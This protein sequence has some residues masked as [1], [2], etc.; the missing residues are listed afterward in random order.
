MCG[1][2]VKTRTTAGRT[3]HLLCLQGK[4]TLADR[5]RR[6]W[7][8]NSSHSYLHVLH[9]TLDV[10]LIY[11]FGCGSGALWP[12]IYCTPQN[13]PYNTTQMVSL[14][15]V[16]LNDIVLR[17]N[18]RFFFLLFHFIFKYPSRTLRHMSHFLFGLLYFLDCPSGGEVWGSAY[19][20]F[21]S[22]GTGLNILYFIFYL[23]QTSTS[24]KLQ[25]EL[26]TSRT[27][28]IYLRQL[29]ISIINFS[30]SFHHHIFFKSWQKL[31]LYQPE[32]TEELWVL[33]Q[34]SISRIS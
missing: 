21:F 25:E 18:S 13:T 4:S 1:S 28:L 22:T 31:D 24:K 7:L 15:N 17:M 29:L 8:A 16:L 34:T 27:L 11:S 9:A 5:Y 23:C 19:I 14:W 26:R 30:S 2:R 20:S 12:I 32:E 3:C 33:F 10:R 6:L